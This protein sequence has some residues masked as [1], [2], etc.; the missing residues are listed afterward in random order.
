MT[1][2][3]CAQSLNK[4]CNAI[5]LVSLLR[6]VQCT[7][8][9]PR[10]ALLTGTIAKSFDDMSLPTLCRLLLFARRCSLLFQAALCPRRADW[11]R[12]VQVALMH[13]CGVADGLLRGRGE[14]ALRRL[15]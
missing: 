10:L 8:L 1:T 3:G 7:S 5:L 11:G 2:R 14:L 9:H 6:V 13:P 12:V 15:P 4:F